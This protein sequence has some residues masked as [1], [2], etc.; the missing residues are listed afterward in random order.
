MML[1][2]MI[3]S[4]LLVSRQLTVTGLATLGGKPARD[5]VLFLEGA[6][7]SKPLQGAK[8]DQTNM[9]FVPH[10]SVVTVG[11][12]VRFPNDDTVMHN[13][14]AHYDAKRF[15]LGMYA[16]G[17]SKSVAFPKAGL[18]ALLCNVHPEMSAYIYVV[19]TPY[20]GVS[21]SKGRFRIDNVEPGR[22]TVKAWHESGRTFTQS[23]NLGQDTALEVKLGR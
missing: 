18:V 19:D 15:D 13:I 8:V 17:T 21:D 5:A 6:P 3:V 23:V 2:P 1:G 10:V 20:F 22:Y 11:T 14:F 16:R 12:T 7:K 4:V 9:R